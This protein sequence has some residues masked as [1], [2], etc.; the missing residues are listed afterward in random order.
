MH[1]SK[2]TTFAKSVTLGAQFID[3]HFV[4]DIKDMYTYIYIYIYIYFL[5]R[6]RYEADTFRELGYM[7]A[8]T[9]T[10][11]YIYIYTRMNPCISMHGA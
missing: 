3:H 11:I 6:W 9:H 10:Y 5:R 4:S 1:A 2:L 7:H 8:E